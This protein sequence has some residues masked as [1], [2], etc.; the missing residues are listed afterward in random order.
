[1]SAITET[2]GSKKDQS[3]IYS[4][5]A[6]KEGTATA[7]YAD[8]IYDLG[9]KPEML[10][11]EHVSGAGD[12]ELDFFHG[13]NQET[14]QAD[15][16]VNDSLVFSKVDPLSSRIYRRRNHQYIALKSTSAVFRIEAW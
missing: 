3:G 1:M 12:L 16:P 4:G 13:L 15:I 7:N 10:Y 9:F 6:F 2:I 8:N 5:K 11:I 14:G